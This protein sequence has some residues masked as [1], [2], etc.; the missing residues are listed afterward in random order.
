MMPQSGEDGVMDANAASGRF[1]WG[2]RAALLALALAVA[3]SGRL[4]AAAEAQ[5]EAGLERALLAFAV[6]RGLNGVISVAQG[7]E[8]AV[9]P[10]GV[11]VTFAPGQVLDPVND[12]VEQFSSVMLFAAAS[13]GLQKLL[14]SASAWVPLAVATAIAGL[15]WMLLAFPG[16]G[17]APPGPTR[18]RAARAAG[19]A[20]LALL[21]LR[22]AVPLTAL[23]AEGAYRAVLAPSYQQSQQTLE[24]A[25]EDLTRVA[26][27]P[28][29]TTVEQQ[30]WLDQARGWLSATRESLDVEAR[31]EALQRTATAITRSVVD[32]IAVFV[33]QTVLVPLLFLGALLALLRRSLA[34]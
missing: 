7:T 18:A 2:W 3:L 29:A 8:I 30:G 25:R 23:L 33:V 16:R 11:G 19:L 15:A 27:E 17:A 32:L 5:V 9:Q 31:I 12:L 1:E 24:Q 26:R 13:L 6:A 21:A 22:L 4:D 20:V 14:L 10:A 28:P 34:T